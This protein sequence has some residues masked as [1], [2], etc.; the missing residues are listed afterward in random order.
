[1]G[2]R[3]IKFRNTSGTNATYLMGKMDRDLEARVYEIKKRLNNFQAMVMLNKA[4]EK[5]LPR[6][7]QD[8]ELTQLRKYYMNNLVEN[9]ALVLT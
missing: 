4:R 6:Y 3:V 2:L 5:G 9:M 7:L 1:M 8:Q